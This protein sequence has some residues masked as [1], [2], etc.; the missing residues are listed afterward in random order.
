M[1]VENKQQFALLRHNHLVTLVLERNILVA[2]LNQEGESLLQSVHGSVKV[3]QVDVPK[4]SLIGKRP[5]TTSAVVRPVI[6]DTGEI[7]PLGMPELVAHEVEVALS[8]KRHG[9]HADH[10]VHGDATVDNQVGRGEVRHAII[11]L[12][13]HKAERDGLVADKRLVVTLAVANHLLLVPP[14]GERVHN[15]PHLPL[16]IGEFLKE[17]D[18]HVRR[19]HSKAVVK[20]KPSLSY[21]ARQSGHAGNVLRDRDAT[22]TE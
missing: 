10:L 3:V 18:P 8:T 17:L 5:L 13:V 20:P 19:R 4:M 14:V 12:L 16:V 11:H 22:R 15:V 21:W 6:A 2:V 1:K 9:E 7:D